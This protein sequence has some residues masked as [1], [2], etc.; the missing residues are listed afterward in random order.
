MCFHCFVI[1]GTDRPILKYLYKY[2]KVN[3]ATKWF[4][5][6]VELL[7]EEDEPRLNTIKVNH[8]VDAE[9]C[10]AEML[11][12]WREKKPDGS[13]NQLIEAFREPNIGLTDLALKID[14]MLI[15]GPYMYTKCI[16]MIIMY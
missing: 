5:I 13:W 11:Q 14:E 16:N 15:K 8:P 12:L 7:D 2:V 6:G 9:K 4:E 1:T 10:A 3:I